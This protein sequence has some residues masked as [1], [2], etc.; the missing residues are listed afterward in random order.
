MH[1][2]RR[3]DEVERDHIRKALAMCNGHKSRTAKTLGI[4]RKTLRA[5]LKRYAIG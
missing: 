2:V 3:L 1:S 5:K 4:D